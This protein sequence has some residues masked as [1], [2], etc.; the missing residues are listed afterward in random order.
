MGVAGHAHRLGGGERLIPGSA[1]ELP[2]GP[3]AGGGG[4]PAG[5]RAGAPPPAPDVRPVGQPGRRPRDAAGAPDLGRPPAPSAAP[6][7]RRFACVLTRSSGRRSNRGPPKR[8][9][10]SDLSDVPPVGSVS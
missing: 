7:S 8:R 9:H 3:G 5:E 1:G 4:T 2:D 10:L 6:E